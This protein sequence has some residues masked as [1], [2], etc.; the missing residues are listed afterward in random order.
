MMDTTVIRSAR[1][2]LALEVRPEGLLVR[3][4]LRATDRQIRDFIAQHRE[5]IA[6]A[7]AR[8]AQRRKEAGELPPLTE[9]ALKAL[10][11]Q[12]R[13][14]LP[15]RVA[16][17]APLIGVTYGKITIRRQRSRWGSCSAKGNLSFNCLLML[18]PP[19][20]IDSVVV[21]E[22]CHRREMNHS[23]RFYA[24]VLR[25]FPDYPQCRAWLKEHGGA[26]MDRMT[27]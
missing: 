8:Q 19:Q 11:E 16:H 10:T 23:D 2:T 9:E 1:T 17:Y 18:M 13:V 5:W 6:K 15:E 14:C 3:A 26:L 24:Q 22:L 7:A 25:V 12:A 20:V 27:G 21:H 4:P